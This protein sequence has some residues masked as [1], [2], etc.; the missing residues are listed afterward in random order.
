MNR[1]KIIEDKF[2][3]MEENYRTTNKVDKRQFAFFRNPENDANENS[4]TMLK[5]FIKSEMGVEEDIEFQVVY[6]LR[7]RPDDKPRS[8]VASFVKRKDRETILKAAP[9]LRNKVY[10]VNEQF[11]QELNDRRRA[12]YPVYREAR[13]RGQNARLKGDKLFIDGR[14]YNPSPQES[15]TTTSCVARR[16]P[17]RPSGSGPASGHDRRRQ[18]RGRGHSNHQY[19]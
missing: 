10:S 15:A 19:S 13:D 3:G 11:P 12:L 8:M 9:N 2:A 6:R 5:E 4:E 18:P 16:D 14:L 7:K 17:S 1:L